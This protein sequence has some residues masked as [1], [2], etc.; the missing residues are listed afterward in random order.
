MRNLWF[1]RYRIQPSLIRSNIFFNSCPR[2]PLKARAE[3]HVTNSTDF[4]KQTDASNASNG[5]NGAKVCQGVGIGT[6][7]FTYVVQAFW[8]PNA[9]S[10]EYKT[11]RSGIKNSES[12][13][14]DG[15][16]IETSKTFL[17]QFS[18]YVMLCRTRSLSFIIASTCFIIKLLSSFQFSKSFFQSQLGV[19][20]NT[21]FLF[22]KRPSAE[23][24]TL[25]PRIM[26]AKN[27][28]LQQQLPLK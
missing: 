28:S 25:P 14:K 6:Q 11:C 23:E 9:E 5:Q 22:F 10:K 27:G 1:W 26:E 7:L 17:I 2:S 3:R 20:Q 21:K 16:K 4:T 8:A 19:F 18:C 15:R 13:R 24:V 12:V